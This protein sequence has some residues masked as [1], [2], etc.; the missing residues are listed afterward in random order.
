MS[1]HVAQGLCE[2]L[3]VLP[4]SHRQSHQTP[5]PLWGLHSVCQSYQTLFPQ[6]A[7]QSYQ[8]LFPQ[9]ACQ[10]YLTLFHPW[11]LSVY[12]ILFLRWVCQSYQTLFP[13]W[14][15]PSY[16]TLF[17]SS[18]VYVSPTKLYFL[19]GVCPSYQTLFL[20]WY[21]SVLPNTLSSLV[22]VSVTTLVAQSW[23]AT[24]EGQQT[25]PVAVQTDKTVQGP[26]KGDRGDQCEASQETHA[27]QKQKPTTSKSALAEWKLME[28]ICSTHPLS[29][30]L[31]FTVCTRRLGNS[32]IN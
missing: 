23:E 30:N 15:C 31:S 24:R 19:L 20:P 10:S 1:S 6:W 29:R 12:R 8:T 22:S 27:H 21:L 32:F 16:Q 11:C 4:H 18:L 17:L 28:V 13:Q 9:W 7:C 5:L 2:G 26:A 14:A 3:S 25:D